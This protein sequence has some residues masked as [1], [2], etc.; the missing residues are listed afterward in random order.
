LTQVR[1]F[2]YSIFFRILIFKYVYVEAG[3]ENY[4]HIRPLAYPNSDI[5]LLCFSIMNR[6]SL[7]NIQKMWIHEIRK[8]CGNRIPIILVG[9][10]TDLRNDRFEI[11]RMA[12]K[13]QR[14][15][16]FDEANLVCEQFKLKKYIECSSLSQNG[17]KSVFDEAIKCAIVYKNENKQKHQSLTSRNKF[18]LN[19]SNLS[20][21]KKKSFKLNNCLIA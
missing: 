19:N 16:S 10:K 15:V 17:L 2:I 3:Q 5:V 18:I 21:K 11:E 8:Y 20:F 13:K 9:T 6:N 4:E 12:K 7:E 1:S 14:P